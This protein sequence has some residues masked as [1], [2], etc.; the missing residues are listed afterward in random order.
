MLLQRGKKMHFLE[1]V[2]RGYTGEAVSKDD[3]DM[4]HVVMPVMEIVDEFELERDGD[5]PLLHDRVQA[6][7]YFDA[8]VEL[9]VRSGVYNQ[10]TGR[11]IRFTREE[12]LE[13]AQGM[14]KAVTVGHGGDAYTFVP[15]K[16]DSNALPGVVAGNPGCPM[17]EELFKKT[18]TSWAKE[19]VVD[20]VT[21]GSIVE[22]DGFDVVR[23]SPSEVIALRRELQYLN[24]ICEKV[25]RPGI[26]RLAAESSVS[27]IGDLAAMA[28]GGF[29]PGD[30]HLIALN[31]ELIITDD[32]LIR[33]ANAMDTPVLNASLACV[34]VGGLAGGP[35]G[36]AV[37]MI[38]SLLADSLIGQADYHLCHPIH[39]KH[40]ATSTPECMWLSSV[41][42]QAF[43]AA[44][45]AVIVCDIYP[46]SGAGTKEL[47]KEVA[48]NALAITVSGGHLEG[49]GSCDGLKPNCS[50]LEARLMGEVGKAAA[51][52]GLTRAEA[53]PIIRRLLSE[54]KHVFT[55][56]NEGLPFD[57]VYGSDGE[58]R[59]FW[60]AM[61]RE[62]RDELI[63][64]GLKL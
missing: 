5:A 21:C 31:N 61:Y 64:L 11:V 43:D 37:C 20:M 60:L 51:A 16:P 53:E 56:G 18:V 30:A 9:L 46:K 29:Q 40:I 15:R 38:A 10:S 17:T 19:P 1:L 55:E 41:V 35:E 42:C 47:L 39:I 24:E 54:Y 22:V 8:A 50:G 57:E 12:I 28:P 7:A 14:P 48:A 23:A 44:A 32:N 3:W 33:V 4:D 52:Q 59:D 27:E 25:G 62:V 13:A 45:P 49:V 63:S 26:G 2:S 34:M 6:S 36:A 58:P